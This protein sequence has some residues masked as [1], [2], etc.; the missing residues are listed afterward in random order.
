M[1]IKPHPTKGPGHWYLIENIK[2]PD[3]NGKMKRKQIFTPF[4]GSEAEARIADDQING[5]ESTTAYPTILEIL[6]RYMAAYQN[7]V[8]PNTYLAMDQALKH[9]LPY[10]GE[11]RIPLILDYHHE[12]YKTRRLAQTYLPGKHWQTP[13]Q[14]TP[15]ESV[16]RKPATRSSINRELACLKSILSYAKKQN[17]IVNSI[18]ILFS[19][20]QS[21]GKTV[22][23]LAPA[24]ISALLSKMQGNPLTLAMLMFWG[25]LRLSEAANLTWEYI[26]LQN[27]VMLIQ[28]K[29]GAVQPVPILGDLRNELERKNETGKTGYICTNPKNLDED[30]NPKPYGCILKALRTAAKRAGITKAINHHLL[31]H[32]CGTILMMS[33]AQQRGVQGIL[34]HASIQT[35]STYTHMAAQFLQAE[36]LKMSSLINKGFAGS[37]NQ[38]TR[39]DKGCGISGIK[40]PREAAK[41]KALRA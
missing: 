23:P 35:T 17:I 5:R 19:K 1:S 18:P 13:D 27:N 28:G 24:E 20:R 38:K 15:E 10:Y 8:R 25:G 41:T 9:L 22:I 14:D 37:K 6:P 33:G 3:K 30:G 36:G 32:T 31:R 4:E 29:G 40:I 26:D 21:T 11:K 12:E 2:V 34:R 39:A 16:K 7:N